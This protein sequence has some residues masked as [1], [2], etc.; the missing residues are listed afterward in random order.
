MYRRFF[1]LFPTRF[2]FPP[3]TY[4]SFLRFPTNN[5][6]WLCTEYCPWFSPTSGEFFECN[7]KSMC[8]IGSEGLS[9][10]KDR[11][12]RAKC[13]AS[14][15]VM[16]EDRALIGGVMDYLCRSNDNSGCLTTNRK[17]YNYGKLI[18]GDAPFRLNMK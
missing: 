1:G 5:N 4:R 16:C 9:C 2:C 11:G 15:P 7:D 3:L 10:C 18:S 6:T 8:D 13:Q 12:G 14:F 17:C